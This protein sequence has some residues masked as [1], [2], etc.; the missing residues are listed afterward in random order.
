MV[1]FLFP[2]HKVMFCNNRNLNYFQDSFRWWCMSSLL[3]FD[4]WIIAKILC[5]NCWIDTLKDAFYGFINWVENL[6]LAIGL[7]F[8]EINMLDIAKFHIGSEAGLVNWNGMILLWVNFYFH[9]R[10][11]LFRLFWFNKRSNSQDNLHFIICLFF[12][13]TWCQLLFFTLHLI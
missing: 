8:L 6:F 3:L 11:E 7:G 1:K 4:H 2:Y 5:E 12:L 10:Y 13:V 9:W